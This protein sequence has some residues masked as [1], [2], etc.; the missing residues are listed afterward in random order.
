MTIDCF[1][2]LMD[3][4]KIGRVFSFEGLTCSEDPALRI[5][6]DREHTHTYPLLEFHMLCLSGRLFNRIVLGTDLLKGRCLGAWMALQIASMGELMMEHRLELLNS[7]TE[8]KQKPHLLN[9]LLKPVTCNGFVYW[10]FQKLTIFML[11]TCKLGYTGRLEN[12]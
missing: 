12:T 4:L 5:S 1:K 9:A 3:S 7:S 10:I 11:N 6:G 8:A 2:F